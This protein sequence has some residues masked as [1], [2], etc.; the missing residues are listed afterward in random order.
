MCEHRPLQFDFALA[1][2]LTPA[3]PATRHSV[4]VALCLF[5][6]VFVFRL[7]ALTKLTGSQFL[8]PNAGD[9]Q[10]YNDWALRILRGNWTEHTAFYGLPLYAY[11]LAGIYKV[12]G[13]SPFMPGL[14]QAG[15]EGGTAVLLYKLARSFL[16]GPEIPAKK[17]RSAAF[18]EAR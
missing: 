15:L 4:I 14:L 17:N 1:M 2:K 12:C 16:P 7:F 8:L 10:F 6:G 11:L 18:G 9:M 3:E 5:V 13:Y